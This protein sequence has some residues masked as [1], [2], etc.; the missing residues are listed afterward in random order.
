M[1]CSQQFTSTV[2]SIKRKSTDWEYFCTFTAGTC[3]TWSWGYLC[4]CTR[5]RCSTAG[6]S[7]FRSSAPTC[8]MNFRSWRTTWSVTCPGWA[9]RS[10]SW[11][12]WANE[13]LN[14]EPID[15]KLTRNNFNQQLGNFRSKKVKMIPASQICFLFF[16]SVNW[17]WNKN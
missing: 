14:N 9:P 10:V 11:D 16:S 5:F 1:T 3:T 6:C 17:I 13:E 2:V 12:H 4:T 7:T 15:R 8:W